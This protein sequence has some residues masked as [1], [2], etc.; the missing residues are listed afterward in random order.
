MIE[1]LLRPRISVILPTYRRFE[2]LLDTA[3]SLLSQLY[4]HFE[5]IVAD[6]NPEWPE[7]L[8]S[9]LRAVLSDF[10]V[11]IVIFNFAP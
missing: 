5:I 6:Q 1:T 2:P 8:K 3:G 7:E 11:S 10:R 9:R 4:E